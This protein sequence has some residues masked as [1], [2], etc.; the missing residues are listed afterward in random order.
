MVLAAG[1]LTSLGS[2]ENTIRL[3]PLRHG[4]VEV[5]GK[6]GVRGQDHRN[7]GKTSE[8]SYGL[9]LRHFIHMKQH[10]SDVQLRK[11][12]YSSVAERKR[13][14]SKKDCIIHHVRH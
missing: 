11:W 4:V 14:S 1:P 8:L 9:R 2:R 7:I 3:A 5:S 12:S 13:V 10:V 6:A